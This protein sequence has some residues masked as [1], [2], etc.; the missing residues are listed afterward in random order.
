MVP[1][2]TIEA[3]YQADVTFCYNSSNKLDIYTLFPGHSLFVSVYHPLKA[4][5]PKQVTGQAAF[6]INSI[7]KVVERIPRSCKKV[8]PDFNSIKKAHENYELW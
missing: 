7:A 8:A 5:E 6:K 3:G 4:I 1:S 2:T